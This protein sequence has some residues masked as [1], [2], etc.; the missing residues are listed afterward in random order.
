MGA[1]MRTIEQRACAATERIHG[2][3]EAQCSAVFDLDCAFEHHAEITNEIYMPVPSR[4]DEIVRFLELP[5]AWGNW[6]GADE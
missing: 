1:M 3:I 4:V 5:G 6:L 2:A